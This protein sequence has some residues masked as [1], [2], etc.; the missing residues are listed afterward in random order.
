MMMIMMMFRIHVGFDTSPRKI[1][2]KK[3]PFDSH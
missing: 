1:K 3:N 2:Q